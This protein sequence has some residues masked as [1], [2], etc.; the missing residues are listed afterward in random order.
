MP[1]DGPR[2]LNI[3]GEHGKFCFLCGRA[4]IW[5]GELCLVPVRPKRDLDLGGIYWMSVPFV[6]TGDHFWRMTLA[7]WLRGSLVLLDGVC[8]LLCLQ[9]P[10]NI[11]I[12]VPLFFEL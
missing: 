4:L 6:G 7:V 2:D 11:L 3:H 12:S 9:D 5:G 8:A 1:W 10:W